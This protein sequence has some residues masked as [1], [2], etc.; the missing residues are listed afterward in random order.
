M[1]VV[2]SYRIAVA[3]TSLA[4]A[5]AC[6]RAWP[7]ES[8][9]LITDLLGREYVFDQEAAL[10]LLNGAIQG[11][12]SDMEKAKAKGQN[13]DFEKSG[14]DLYGILLGLGRRGRADAK[15]KELL[16]RLKDE[17]GYVSIPSFLGLGEER[18]RFWKS[19]VVVQKNTGDTL[20]PG[21]LQWNFNLYGLVREIEDQ[22]TKRTGDRFD[23]YKGREY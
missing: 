18:E 4:F 21:S 13:Y 11:L 6:G 14:I 7:K 9:V 22:V 19:C 20:T 15:L 2:C 17:F 8:E 10:Q 16:Y 5:F 3:V 12:R 1:R 23:D